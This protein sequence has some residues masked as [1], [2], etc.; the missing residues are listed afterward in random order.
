MTMT[1]SLLNPTKADV[2]PEGV[3]PHESAKPP[4]ARTRAGAPAR[5]ARLQRILNR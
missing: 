4:R 2:S 5:T 1:G 3:L